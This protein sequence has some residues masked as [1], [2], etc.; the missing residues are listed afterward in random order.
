MPK[1]WG[2]EYS[3]EELIPRL[4]DLSQIASVLPCELADGNERGCKVVLIRNA[5]GLEL[6]VLTDRGMSIYDLSLRGVPLAFKTAVGP[7]HP[8]HCSSKGLDWLSSWPAG[9]LTPCGLANVG[10]P[11][12]DESGEAGLHGRIASI[13]ARNVSYGGRWTQEGNYEL[14]VEGTVTETSFFGVNLCL[15]RRISALIDESRFWIEDRVENRGF[16]AAPLMLLQHINLGFPLIDAGSRLL[17]PAGVTV[18]RDAEA[19]AGIGEWMCFAEPQKSYREQ[20]FYHDCQA[21]AENRV[22]ATVHN[23][24][25]ENGTGIGLYVQY[26]KSE[27]P[28]LVQW[29]M[30]KQGTYVCG[31]EPA[32]CHVA[33]RSEERK[34]GTLVMLAGGE[35]RSFTVEIGVFNGS[36]VQ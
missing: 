13:A 23:P 34:R 17:L 24:E 12:A 31:I 6:T 9:L 1:L 35:R 30:M 10:S 27:Y 7:L 22:R 20:V 3:K 5:A 25:F 29:K 21:D 11:C 36:P 4:G 8:S 15:R 18:A 16:E 26:L 32:N 14:F 33:G 28:N 19:Q 2:K